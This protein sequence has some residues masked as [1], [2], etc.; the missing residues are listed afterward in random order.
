MDVGVVLLCEFMLPVERAHRW[1]FLLSTIELALSDLSSCT[2]DARTRTH[3][4]P[5]SLF[6][7]HSSHDLRLFH[8]LLTL[9]ADGLVDSPVAKP[10]RLIF[11]VWKFVAGG[12][13]S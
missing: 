6:F 9:I 12:I 4:L 8:S 13:R 3:T 5:S 10:T 11:F 1:D 7:S 2:F